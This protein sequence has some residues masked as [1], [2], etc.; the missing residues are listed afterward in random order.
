MHRRNSGPVT[1]PELRSW[2]AQPRAAVV[3]LDRSDGIRWCNDAFA[4]AHNAIAGDLV[5]KNLVVL[6]PEKVLEE[7][8][9]LWAP[10]HAR[11]ERVEYIQVFGG[12]RV[13]TTGATLEPSVLGE[14]LFVFLL[15][16]VAED[17]PAE[18]TPVASSALLAEYS[19]LSRAELRVLHAFAQGLS[20][21]EIAESQHRS[22]HTVQ[23]HLKSIYSKLGIHREVELALKLGRSGIGAFTVEEWE[24]IVQSVPAKDPS[25]RSP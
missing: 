18:N 1:L 15:L 22:L 11:G 24:R 17:A 13:H 6:L 4:T 5:G 25:N 19:L 8:R 21:E 10:L 2:I 3:V 7:R 12:Q 14:G 23:I 9:K 20:R 16:P